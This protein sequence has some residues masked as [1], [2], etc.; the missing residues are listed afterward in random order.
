[1]ENA[2]ALKLFRLEL[3]GCRSQELDIF[4][5]MD[6]VDAL[7]GAY[8]E[9]LA[10]D[11]HNEAARYHLGLIAM[12]NLDFATAE[13]VFCRLDPKWARFSALVEVLRL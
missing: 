11:P 1:V 9:A 8:Q 6:G 3:A 12:R 13:P 10:V 2:A 7:Q 5:P 4:Q